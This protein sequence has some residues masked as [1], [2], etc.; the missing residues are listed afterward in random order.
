MQHVS[1]EAIERARRTILVSDVFAENADRI[2]EAT[3]ELEEGFIIVAV[4]NERHKFDSMHT[5]AI[6][7]MVQRVPE[8]EGDGWTM[9]FSQGATT[10]SILVRTDKMADLS[11]Q[12]IDAIQRIVARRAAKIN[13][14]S[15]D[16]E[17]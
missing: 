1:P 8:L 13:A 14:E 6:T 11:Q 15:A 5:V 17:N 10:A 4:V 9:V 3:Q 2:V 12:R 7:E 16:L